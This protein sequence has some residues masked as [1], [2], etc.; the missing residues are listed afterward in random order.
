MDGKVRLDLI[1]PLIILCFS[2]SCYLKPEEIEGK[3]YSEELGSVYTLTLYRDTFI[4]ILLHDGDT[5]KNV[6][7][8]TL[9]DYVYLHSWKSQQELLDTS[10]GGCSGCQL[11]YSNN[12]LRNYLDPDSDPV[13]IFEK[14]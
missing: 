11:F 10:R 4:Q 7:K 2:T 8:Y 5:F 3:Y 1:F 13:D 9:Y 6:G 12:K 14:R